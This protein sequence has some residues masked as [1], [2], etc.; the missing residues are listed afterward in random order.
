RDKIINICDL[1]IWNLYKKAKRTP[2]RS[3]KSIFPEDY[4][5]LDCSRKQKGLRVRSLEAKRNPKP[6]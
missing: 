2:I 3:P 6:L 1:S 4:V 5:T